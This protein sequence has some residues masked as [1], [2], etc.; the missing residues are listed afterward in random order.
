M[1]AVKM[2]MHRLLGMLKANED[3]INKGN[4]KKFVHLYVKSQSKV[5]GVPAK[6]VDKE[7]KADYQSIRKLIKNN[8]ILRCARAL[9]NAATAVSIS[10]VEYTVADAIAR[11]QSLHFEKELLKT[12]V[13]QYAAVR[14]SY[15]IE[16]DNLKEATSKYIA[17][18]INDKSVVS[19]EKIAQLEKDY[20]ELHEKEILDPIGIAEEIKKL[21]KSIK[22]FETEVDYV[23][24]DSNAS[25]FV[26]IEL[27]E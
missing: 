2:S 12:L 20:R 11:K 8:N 1:A 21:E 7:I 16:R 23:L 17:G 3:I 10:G 14:R 25:T 9:S 19:A 6:E 15:D 13:E 18:L 24:S 4:S 27:D 26:E 22:D 5:A